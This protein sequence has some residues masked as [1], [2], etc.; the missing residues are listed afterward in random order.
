MSKNT[1]KSL[2]ELIFRPG[3]ALH[4]LAKQA[5]TAMGLAAALRAGLPPEMSAELRSASLR[6]DGTLVVLA[7]SPAWAARLRFERETLLARCHALHPQVR[8]VTVRVSGSAGAE[9]G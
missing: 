4:D 5:E 8:R 7:S 1:P 2:S 9:P 6:D 3:S